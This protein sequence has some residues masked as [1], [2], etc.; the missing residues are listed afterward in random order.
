M[1]EEAFIFPALKKRGREVSLVGVLLAQHQRGRAITD[2][3]V[4][5][6]S[7]T[8]IGAPAAE[9][10]AAL[11]SFARMYEAHTAIEDTVVF[12]AWKETLSPKDLAEYGERF[13]AIEKREF[14]HDGFEDAVKQIAAVESSL[15]LADLAN[16]TAP[17]PP[18]R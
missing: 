10:A 1:L 7:G 12:P 2:Y 14:G 5:V 17:L 15:G 4:A 13:E 18:R 16:F 9:V 6:T 3:V 11:E 8:K